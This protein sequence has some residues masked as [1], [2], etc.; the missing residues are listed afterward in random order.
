MSRTKELWNYEAEEKVWVGKYLNSHNISHWHTDYE[1]VYVNTGSLDVMVEGL[2]YNLNEGNAILIDSKMIHN[3]HAKKDNTIASIIIFDES[4]VKNHLKSLE[5]TSPLLSSNYNIP[6]LYSALYQELTSKPS[7][8]EMNTK[9][10]IQ[11]ILIEIFRNEK[12]TY[13]KAS[14]KL[15]ENLLNL[16]NEINSNYRYYKFE[17]AYQLMNMNPSYFSRFFHNMIGISFAKYLN[18]VKVEKAV[19]LIHDNPNQSMTDIADLCGFQTI[20]NFNRI[21]KSYTGYSPSQIPLNYTF[22]GLQFH[23]YSTTNNP[24]LNNCK[25]IEFSS[26]HN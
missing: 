1:L 17:D 3:M 22:N 18:C 11:S 8:Y 10:L 21:F 2:N 19:E 15:N 5:L 9:I 12:T 14:K 20:R 7:F 23:N 25:L 24:T 13:K 16:L 26:P 4:L 6:K